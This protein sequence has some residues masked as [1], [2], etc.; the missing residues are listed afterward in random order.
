MPFET[1]L[2][3]PTRARTRKA[4]NGVMLVVAGG[5]VATLMAFAG[6]CDLY[7]SWDARGRR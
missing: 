6:A 3:G 4:M 7:L 1:D 2:A 5:Y